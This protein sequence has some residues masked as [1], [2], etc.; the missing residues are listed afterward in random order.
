MK[1]WH[2]LLKSIVYISVFRGEWRLS[3]FRMPS[4]PYPWRWVRVLRGVLWGVLPF[5]VRRFFLWMCSLFSSFLN[6]WWLIFVLCNRYVMIISQDTCRILLQYGGKTK[7]SANFCR[8]FWK[9]WENRLFCIFYEGF[10]DLIDFILLFKREVFELCRE[11]SCFGNWG[12][13]DY[14][15]EDLVGGAIEFI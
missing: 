8:F 15:A 3:Y 2:L 13:F 7:K 6:D 5:R 1:D 12:L 9:I 10:D 4:L 14:V 11:F